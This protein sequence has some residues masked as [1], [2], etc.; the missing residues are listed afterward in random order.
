MCFT[1]FVSDLEMRNKLGIAYISIMFTNIALHFT[2]MIKTLILIIK[3]KIKRCK[4]RRHI[5]RCCCFWK[6]KMRR[7]ALY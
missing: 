5:Y 4:A 6:K 3:L 1:E 7:K 2:C